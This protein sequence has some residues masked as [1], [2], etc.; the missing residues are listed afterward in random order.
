MAGLY[1]PRGLILTPLALYLALS[2]H[3]ALSAEVLLRFGLGGGGGGG[4]GVIQGFG[5]N[6]KG[7]GGIQVKVGGGGDEGSMT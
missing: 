7:R 3:R 1:T 2:R 4:L 5:E 6:R